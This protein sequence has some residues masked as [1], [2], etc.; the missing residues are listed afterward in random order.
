MPINNKEFLQKYMNNYFIEAG[1]FKGDTIQL[2]LDAGFQYIRSIELN[3][4]NFESCYK[5]FE[6]E[7]N[8][9]LYFGESEKFLWSMIRDIKEPFTFWGDAHY[10][11]CGETY[12]TSKG[13]TFSSIM[14]DLYTIRLHPIKNHTIIIDDIRD[15][16][17]QNMDYVKLDDILKILKS[18]NP[19]YNISY[20]TGDETNE[21]FKNDILVAKI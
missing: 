5:R 21:I 16:G 3:F 13:S 1:S 12:V 4:K 9:T 10:S 15:F 8:V 2:A 7:K 19:D 20:D 18:I 17:T 14:S 6:H 11:G